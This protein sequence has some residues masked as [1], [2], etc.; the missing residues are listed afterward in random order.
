M[1]NI[2]TASAIFLLLV[3]LSGARELDLTKGS[4]KLRRFASEVIFVVEAGAREK[5]SKRLPD[6][7]EVF[8]EAEPLETKIVQGH[9]D[10]FLSLSGVKN[11][12]LAGQTK[13]LRARLEIYLGPKEELLEKA[14]KIDK[15]ISLDH[16]HTYWK[17]W[18]GDK[19]ITRAVIFVATDIFRGE[20][21]DDRLIEN[22]LGAFGLPSESG[23]ID[24]SCSTDEDTVFDRLQPVDEA[25]LKFYYQSVPANTKPREFDKIF[26]AKWGH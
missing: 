23:E 24:E 3:Q 25:L 10:K 13:G 16:G 11:Q 6:N 19:Y 20:N 14:E 2:Q 17:W 7:V 12:P 26:R 21:L 4:S 22:L 18:D 8:I 15:Q 1:K 5:Y 9:L